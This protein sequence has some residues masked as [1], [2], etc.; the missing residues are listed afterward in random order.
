MAGGFFYL[1]LKLLL[2]ICCKNAPHYR[3]IFKLSLNF[4]TLSLI[5]SIFKKPI[6]LVI[7]VDLL[8]KSKMKVNFFLLTLLIDKNTTFNFILL[9]YA[10][11][12]NN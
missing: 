9:I 2:R 11:R 1:F 8:S 12:A 10:I 4:F 6:V 5:S 3:I 7:D